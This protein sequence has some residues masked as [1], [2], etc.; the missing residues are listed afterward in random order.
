MGTLKQLLPLGDKPVIR[1]CYDTIAAAGIQQV[2]VVIDGNIN[3]IP[4]ALHGTPAR[5]VRNTVPGSQMADS[6]RK[7][8][9]AIDDRCSGVLICLSDHPL[10]SIGT[11][12]A[13]INAH[14]KAPDTIVIPVYG[15]RRGHP[16]LFPPGAVREIASGATLRDVIRKDASRLTL[17]HVA[18]EGV[19]LDMDTDDD[20]RR[21]VANY[22]A[23]QSGYGAGIKG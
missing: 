18:D 17:L 21:I 14:V 4:E 5:I 8:L 20:Y 12:S 16:S 23:R 11:Y 15:G 2:I 6:V 19:V 1:H 9:G 13:I 10:I 22:T 3:G 7:G